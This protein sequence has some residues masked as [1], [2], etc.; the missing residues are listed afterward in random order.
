MVVLY[1]ATTIIERDALMAFL[2]ENHVEAFTGRRDVIQNLTENPNLSY[3]GYSVLF[4][5]YEVFVSEDQL[6]QAQDLLKDFRRQIQLQTV[7]E[8][9][10]T[11]F[12]T[13]KKYERRL[14]IAAIMTLF[15][16]LVAHLLF[17]YLLIQAKNEKLQF[18]LRMYLKVGFILI[19]TTLTTFFIFC[20][21]LSPL[22]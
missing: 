7:S 17:V 3:E 2:S 8:E 20:D 19:V 22:S 14:M 9:F 16:P 4:A 18:P 5:G 15:I 1:R 12:S 6:E 10:S 21:A 11:E 13:Q